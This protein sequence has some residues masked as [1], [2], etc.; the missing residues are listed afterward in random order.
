LSRIAGAVLFLTVLLCCACVKPKEVERT[1][2][3]PQPAKAPEGASTGETQDDRPLI[4]A[5]G[6][7]L[8]SGLGVGSEEN[9]PAKLQTKIDAG[10]YRYKV[11]NAGVSG[12]TSS[13]GLDRLESIL[14][15]RPAIVIVEFGANDGL[16][17]LPVSVTR[18]NLEAIVGGLQDAGSKIVMA[19]MRLP[20]NYGTEY[21]AAFH[22][23]FADVAAERHAALVPFLLEG[24][25]GHAELNQVDGIHPTAKGYDIVVE[26]V[27]RILA[28]LL[29]KP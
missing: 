21:T 5:F 16:R 2:D 15:L 20:P 9:Y 8:T 28:P 13:Q 24:V 1:R 6:D 7:S 25:G 19:G 18:Q 3:L 29:R 22:K 10:G 23:I 4:V 12:D 11:I 17:G 26:N 14:T 27:F